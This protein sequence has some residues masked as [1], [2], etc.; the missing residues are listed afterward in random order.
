MQLEGEGPWQLPG[1]SADIEM[2]LTPGHTKGHVVLLYSG[3]DGGERSSTCF[4]GDHLAW[5]RAGPLTVFK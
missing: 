3:G 2:I 5:S 4:T 1:G